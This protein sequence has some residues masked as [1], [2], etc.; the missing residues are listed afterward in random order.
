MQE[1]YAIPEFVYGQEEDTGFRTQAPLI[2]NLRPDRVS[3][4]K[5]IASNR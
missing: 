1:K 5:E 4:F 2:G 3:F